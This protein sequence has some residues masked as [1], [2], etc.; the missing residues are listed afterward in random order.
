MDYSNAIHIIPDAAGPEAWVNSAVLPGGDSGIWA[1]EDD[2]SQWNAEPGLTGG[3]YGGDRNSSQP[4]SRSGSEQPPPGKKPRGGPSGGGGGDAGSMSKS[5]A[6]G[7]MFFKT[8]LCCKFRAGTCPYVTNCNFAHGM[9]ELRKPPPNWQEIVA[10]HEEATEQ[11]EEHQIPIMTSSS[12]APSESVSGRAYK[13]RHCKKFYT[14][15]GCPYGDAC[16]FL[17]DEQS[18]ARES[19]A[20]SLSPSVGGGS[21]NSPTAA[22]NGPTILKPSNWKTRI[23]NKWEM[24]GY[25]PFGSKCHF[26]HGAAELHKYGGGLVDVEGRDIASTPDSKQAALS[27]KAPAETTPASTAAPP[28]SDVYHLGIQSQRSTMTSQRSGQLPRPIQKWKG[29]DKI[30]RIYGDWIDETD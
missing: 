11:R 14:E 16:T 19:V 8:K 28:H 20:I 15:E 25:C 26:A 9:E 17:H 4:Q 27:A 7:K 12:V 13:G 24:T 29:P 18:K 3:G 23:C 6:I 22:A 1:T 21:Y 30:S 10:A 5:R 2:Y